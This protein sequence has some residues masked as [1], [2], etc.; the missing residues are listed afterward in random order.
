LRNFIIYK[1]FTKAGGLYVPEGGSS[2]SRMTLG[3][4]YL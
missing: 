2:I 1:G 3:R 4:L